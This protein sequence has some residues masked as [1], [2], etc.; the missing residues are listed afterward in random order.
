M[1][2]DGGGQ[3]DDLRKEMEREKKGQVSLDVAALR[4]DAP[5]NDTPLATVVDSL[6]DTDPWVRAQAAR[7]LGMIHPA[8]TE[9]IPTLIDLLQDTHVEVRRAAAAALGSFGSLAREAAPALTKALSDPDDAVSQIA[10]EALKQIQ[11]R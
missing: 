1:R 3:Y 5:A 8:P 4:S 11:S 2:N 9:T 7:R 10:A 6:K